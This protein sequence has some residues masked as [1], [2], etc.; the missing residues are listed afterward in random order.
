M[1]GLKPAL[2]ATLLLTALGVEAAALTIETFFKRPQF[3]GAKISPG[4]RYV[5][6]ARAGAGE[7]YNLSVID[8]DT[9]SER[10]VT[11][12][13]EGDVVRVVWQTDERMLVFVGDLQRGT[14]QPP[15][16][17]GVVAIDRDG[18]NPFHLSRRFGIFANVY[19]IGG[20]NEI[21]ITS[22]RRG[23]S[24]DVYRVDTKTEAEKILTFSSPGNVTHWVVDFDGV[25]RAA[26]THDRDNDKSAWYVRKGANDPWRK[27]EEDVWTGLKTRPQL[28]STDGKVLFV[29]SRR[30]GDRGAIFEFEVDTGEWRGPVIKHAERDMR[31]GFVFSFEERKLLGLHYV[32]DRPASVW[33]DAKWAK[34]QKSVD[35]VLPE[36]VNELQNGGERWLIVSRSDRDP[37]EVFVLEGDTMKMRKLL[38]YQPWID[39]AKAAPSRWVRYQARDG[40]TIPALLTMAKESEG[41]RVPLVVDIRGDPYGDATIWDY[42]PHVQFLA[43]RGYA[44]LQPQYRGTKGFGWKL[45][46]SG[47]RKIGDEMQD[48]LEDG[49]RWAVAQGIAEPG[50]ACLF[51]VDFGAYAAMWGAVKNANAIKCAVAR[52]GVVSIEY[53]FAQMRRRN[54]SITAQLVGD[55][56]DHERWR[57][58]S[59]V[60]QAARV[61]VPILLAYGAED[62]DAHGVELRRALQRH[63][64]P[65]EWV[66][67][68]EDGIGFR[69]DKNLYDF[70]GRVESF[71]ARHLNATR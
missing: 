27:I 36:R 21:L 29:E 5:A 1:T 40:L 31:P 10:P 66:V 39:P 12:F 25:P 41:K 13:A 33:F 69:L 45:H 67:Y 2:C 42:Q 26:T 43:S 70:Y 65:H 30:H 14:G 23:P 48:D 20:T 16:E 15:R 53:W 18:R 7:R 17:R 19:V 9:H 61:G 58:V 37:G 59:P 49:I 28:F 4:G 52:S 47:F 22:S 55:S 68:D 71:L 51:G 56:T 46:S 63:G 44:V 64:K 3:H 50:R 60:D 8:L 54:V 11:A 38:S 35:A 6:V 24:L 57:R 34:M 32:D 62:R